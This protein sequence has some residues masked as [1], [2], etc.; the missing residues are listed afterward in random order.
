M[1]DMKKHRL[2][3]MA[4][5]LAGVAAFSLMDAGLKLLSSDYP[6]MQVA[7]LRGLAALPLVFAWAM[8]AGGPSSC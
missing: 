7:A 3:G 5:M 6:A 2:A 1:Q 4:A 8:Y